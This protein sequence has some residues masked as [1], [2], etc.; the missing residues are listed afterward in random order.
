MSRWTMLYV[1]IIR[2][3]FRYRFKLARL[4]RWP[5]LGRLMDKAFFEGDDIMVIPK[6]VSGHV[7]DIP[8]DLP[9]PSRED[10]V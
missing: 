4:T 2:R 9:A 3:G 10:L 6:E 7:L 8:V 1:R 5:L